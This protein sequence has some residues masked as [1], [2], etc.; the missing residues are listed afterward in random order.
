MIWADRIAI[1]I[2]TLAGVWFGYVF[3]T[4]DSA[5][6]ANLAYALYAETMARC[7]RVTSLYGLDWDC[8]DVNRITHELR[9][10][11]STALELLAFGFRYVLPVWLALRTIDFI[12]GGP[13]RRRWLARSAS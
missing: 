5:N 12:S 7:D 1:S 8:R 10:L 2:F 13:E 11:A 3:L 4:D 6:Q 9:T